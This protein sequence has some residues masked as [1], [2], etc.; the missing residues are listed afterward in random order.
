MGEALI[1][2]TIGTMMEGLQAETTLGKAASPSILLGTLDM[3]LN[4]R[5]QESPPRRLWPHFIQSHVLK[6]IDPKSLLNTIWTKTYKNEQIG[7]LDEESRFCKA[8]DYRSLL[9][10]AL[11]ISSTEEARN[12]TVRQVASHRK[13]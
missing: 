10:D 5:L 11:L 8:P 6:P 3:F 1:S 7:A 2:V 9:N 12:I 13:Q 4:A